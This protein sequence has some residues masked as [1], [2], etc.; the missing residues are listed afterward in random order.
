MSF[1]SID[2]LKLDDEEDDTKVPNLTTI[3]DDYDSSSKD[4]NYSNTSSISRRVY[5][6]LVAV[7]YL[8][9]IISY[10]NDK[11]KPSRTLSNHV[12]LSFCSVVTILVM[13][14]SILAGRRLSYEREKREIRKY[15]TVTTR[16]RKPGRSISFHSLGYAFIYFI[17]QLSLI[18]FF[19]RRGKFDNWMKVSLINFISSFRGIR[20]EETDFGF[21]QGSES[22]FSMTEIFFTHTL[23]L[24]KEEIRTST[25][26]QIKAHVIWLSK[27]IAKVA[28]TQPFLFHS[29]LH[30]AVRLLRWAKYLLPIVGTCNKLK[31]Q[32]EDGIEKLKL[33]RRTERMF[34][35]WKCLLSRVKQKN[36]L[37]HAV[38]RIQYSFRLRRKENAERKLR[39]LTMTEGNRTRRAANVYARIEQRW[40]QEFVT[41]DIGIALA[42]HVEQKRIVRRTVTM[43]D[44]KKIL[45]CEKKVQQS[46]LFLI[47]PNTAFSV[48]WK[49]LA[50]FCVI[51]EVLN[52]VLLPRADHITYQDLSASLWKGHEHRNLCQ[53]L[54]Q[55]ARHIPSWILRFH[56]AMAYS[57]PQCTEADLYSVGDLA[58]AILKRLIEYLQPLIKFVSFADVFITFFTGDIDGVS[59]V[60]KSFVSR[61]I[62]PG[63]LLQ[64][65]VNPSMKYIGKIFERL[66]YSLITFGPSHILVHLYMI[67]RVVRN[68]PFQGC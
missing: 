20:C 53:N 60:P 51:V 2:R 59:L 35:F 40:A 3:D 43:A 4:E 61:W 15:S 41:A 56:G 1:E 23:S 38:R 64:L 45:Q 52:L 34:T 48:A 11:W 13:Y 68:E 66:I 47:P 63:I 62:F 37:E 31:G 36:A 25:Q 19:P 16:K 67:F 58:L 46:S 21:S 8:I 57:Q 32:I 7:F 18:P 49:C 50:I 9:V 65:Y 24:L 6:I 10:F 28:I 29:R 27:Y 14:D 22:F 42:E 26:K 44:R 33:N 17:S 55:T 54:D 39:F 30:N 5:A 12:H